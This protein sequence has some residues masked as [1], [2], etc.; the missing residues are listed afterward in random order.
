MQGDVGAALHCAQQG[1]EDVGFPGILGILMGNQG[2]CPGGGS[3]VS[4]DHLC[5]KA[6]G[7]AGDGG[8]QVQISYLSTVCH[9]IEK[10]PG[11]L[12][13][14]ILRAGLHPDCPP[15]GGSLAAQTME[16]QFAVGRVGF[17]HAVV[18]GVPEQHQVLVLI[19]LRFHQGQLN[20]RLG[21]ADGNRI[22]RLCEAGILQCAIGGN[23]VHPLGAVRIVGMYA[24]RVPLLGQGYGL[25][26]REGG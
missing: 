25:G 4:G 13:G 9:R 24:G 14:D 6:G 20:Q 26:F 11:Q 12:N 21:G 1:G 10:G 5:Q 3:T 23:G 22:P 8:F 16:G 17:E 2:D 19:F 15:E 18:T 7:G